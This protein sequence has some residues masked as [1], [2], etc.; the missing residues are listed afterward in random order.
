MYPHHRIDIDGFIRENST[1]RNEKGKKMSEQTA[2]VTRKDLK[3]VLASDAVRSRFNDVLGRNSGAFVAAILNAAVLNPEI[4]QC[5]PISVVNAGL[6]AAVMDL[7]ISPALGQAAIIPFNSKDGKKAQFQIMK[8]GIVQLA[9]RTNKYRYIHVD[10]IYEGETWTEERFTGKMTMGG[11]KKS[12]KIIGWVAYFQLLSGY[13]K[14]LVMS[15]EQI[16]EHA[17]KYSKSWSRKEGKF[18]SGSA[19]D[20]NFDRMCE[21]TVLKLLIKNYG[22]LSD[23]MQ[24]AFEV[25]NE[26]GEVVINAEV[27]TNIETETAE[28]NEATDAETTEAEQEQAKWTQEQI[29]REMGYDAG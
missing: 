9:L 3:S 28:E 29:L 17:Q 1:S 23:K 15:N 14:Y 2:I 6:Q 11:A 25:E 22:I 20:T 8:N 13:E 18:Y 10:K 7:S 24:Q 5:D 21:K 19:W 26:T 27:V 4:N 12:N 16:L